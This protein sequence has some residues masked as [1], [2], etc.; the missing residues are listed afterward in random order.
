LEALHGLDYSNRQTLLV[1]NGTAPS[2]VP[3]VRERFPDVHVLET[4]GNL[5]Y[6]GGNNA[7]LRY[8]LEHA[9]DYVLLINN[10]TAAPKDM[11]DI[12]LA[13]TEADASIGMACP[14][15]VSSADHT[16]RYAPTIEWERASAGEVGLD[17]ADRACR[18]ADFAPGCALLIRAA[19]AR[20]IGLL[21]SEYFMYYE[22]VDWSLRC[23]R[24]GFRVV[25]VAAAEIYHQ[26]TPD[27]HTRKTT[28]TC[29]YYLRNQARFIRR[30]LPRR[31]RPYRLWRY[32][33][34][35][36]IMARDAAC[37]GEREAAGAMIDGWWA[38][39]T[40]RHGAQ[41]NRAPA[42][43]QRLFARRANLMI[44]LTQPVEFL[45]RRFPVRSTA[46]A[47]WIAIVNAK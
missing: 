2:P 4:G 11:V 43:L 47:I 37:N 25:I 41:R 38:G 12:L 9:A 3:V 26:G 36:W 40:G 18:D 16:K 1:N 20:V 10:D 45:R 35:C 39:L 34:D 32:T 28:A 17:P 46:R 8:A 5:G 23:K 6:A 29:F 14:A 19:T 30:H 22:D 7:G 44:E 21:N 42:S 13:E 27:Q 15:V 31:Q 33:R 24:A